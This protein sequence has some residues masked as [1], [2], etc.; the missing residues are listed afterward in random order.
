MPTERTFTYTVNDENPQII[1]LLK[2]LNDCIS[3][4]K[5]FE[6]SSFPLLTVREET[7]VTVKSRYSQTI[8]SKGQG[9]ETIL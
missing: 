3:L 5:Y 7:H 1:A 8:L 6:N 9:M 4:F 2:Y